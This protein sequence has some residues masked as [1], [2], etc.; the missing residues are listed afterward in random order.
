MPLTR[1]ALQN[2]GPHLPLWDWYSRGQGLFHYTTAVPWY[3][4][5]GLGRANTNPTMVNEGLGSAMPAGLGAYE[6]LKGMH[7]ID[8][9][10][11]NVERSFSDALPALELV[12]GKWRIPMHI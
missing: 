1:Q 4:E 6:R 3:S 5:R 8:S 9:F 7:V 2:P 11:D 10:K 12:W